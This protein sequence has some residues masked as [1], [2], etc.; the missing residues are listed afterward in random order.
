MVMV[1]TVSIGRRRNL[2]SEP[3]LCNLRNLWI[4]IFRICGSGQQLQDR[5]FIGLRF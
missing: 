5:L 4:F 3:N 1:G 2:T